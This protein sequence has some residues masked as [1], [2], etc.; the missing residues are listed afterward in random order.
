MNVDPHKHTQVELLH[1]WCLN[2]IKKGKYN[3]FVTTLPTIHKGLL[4]MIEDLEKRDKKTKKFLKD[5][6]LI[7]D[8]ME[9]PPNSPNITQFDILSKCHF[10]VGKHFKAFGQIAVF[11]VCMLLIT[12]F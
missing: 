3:I 6:A 1:A 10:L 4:Y 5:Y 7:V 8:G 9:K 11:T 2:L 12:C